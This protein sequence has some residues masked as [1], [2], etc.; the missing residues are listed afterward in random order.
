M[1]ALGRGIDEYTALLQEREGA[2]HARGLE[3]FPGE[4]GWLEDSLATCARRSDGMTRLDLCVASIELSFSTL[5]NSEGDQPP[6]IVAFTS[7]TNF[8][9]KLADRLQFLPA[10]TVAAVTS[11]LDDAEVEEAIR[12]FGLSTRPAVL[13][14]DRSA[15]EGLNLPSRRRLVPYRPPVRPGTTR[16]ADRAARPDGTPSPGHTDASRAPR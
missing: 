16:A 1:E 12:T 2:L 9:K 7:S 10:T 14:A 5:A 8:A 15:E 3:A 4:S 11:D 6:R 13:V